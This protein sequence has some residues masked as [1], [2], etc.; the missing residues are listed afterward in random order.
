MGLQFEPNQPKISCSAR[1][2]KTK[3]HHPNAS[4]LFLTVKTQSKK[5]PV[6][7]IFSLCISSSQ[8]FAQ[9]T[10]DFAALHQPSAPPTSEPPVSASNLRD[11]AAASQP[12]ASR[13]RYASTNRGGFPYERGRLKSGLRL[14]AARRSSRVQLAPV[15]R[16]DLGLRDPVVPSP[17][18]LVP[19]PAA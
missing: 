15:R 11:C 10:S 12:P 1:P 18:L 9:H 17:P 4:A 16:A 5:S 14:P 19:T 8:P 2:T 7:L 3:S 13:G 6:S